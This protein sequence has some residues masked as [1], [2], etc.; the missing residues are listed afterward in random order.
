MESHTFYNLLRNI[1]IASVLI[2]II[3]CLLKFKALNL[4]LRA[5]FIFLIISFVFELA[6]L[7]IGSNQSETYLLQHIYTII[8]CSFIIFIY[9]QI[10]ENRKTKLFIVLFYSLFL[11]LAFW[12]FVLREGYKRED[13]IVN[14]YEAIFVLVLGW[15]YLFKLMNELK[16][17]DLKE[18]YFFWLNFA[19]VMYFS[20]AFIFFL[21][22]AYLEQLPIPLFTFLWGLHLLIN[23]TSNIL[24]SRGI[25]K[26]QPR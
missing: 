10:F 3:C 6:G 7:V 14:T 18:H 19:F 12:W 21:F 9:Y 13:S 5:L 26:A 16:V 17:Y 8:E 2:P 22:Y 25:W 4:I 24:I 23:I 15:S 20:M 1:S 11:V